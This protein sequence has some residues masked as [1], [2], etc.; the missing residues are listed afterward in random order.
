[1]KKMTAVLLAGLFIA[2]GLRSTIVE[3]QD[4]GQAGFLVSLKNGSTI[5][6][7]TLAR[8]ESTGKLRLVM[9]ESATGAAESYAVISMA[10]ADS[11]R[12]SASTTD[13]IRIRLVGGSELRCKEFDLNRDVVTV[14]LGTASR[15][16]VR[17]DEIES[18]TFS[19]A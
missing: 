19:G 7:R 5:R 3:A 15:V 14:K 9:T 10:D 13:S 2:G 1:M 8:D 4:S 6:G 12:A 17:W 11:I 16:E 18:I